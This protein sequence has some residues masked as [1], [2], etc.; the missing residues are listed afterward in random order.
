M[1]VVVVLVLASLFAIRYIERF[2]SRRLA[3]LLG[4]T[5]TVSDLSV[6]PT[7]PPRVSPIDADQ[8]ALLGSVAVQTFHGATI[9]FQGPGS[10]VSS[11]GLILTTVSA[12]PYGSGSYVYQIATARGQ[13]LRARRLTSDRESGLVLLKVESDGL[14]A[15]LFDEQFP[16]VAGQQLE[17]IAGRVQF[18]TFA[19][20]RL[21]LW[22]VGVD[23]DGRVAVSLDRSFGYV[24][25]GGRIIDR[26]GHSV[27]VL[28]YGLSAFVVSAEKV[29]AFIDAYL[30]R[31]INQ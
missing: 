23:V 30:A 4:V 18:S 16:L 19:S 10:A 3:S 13:I 22:V 12:A 5:V 11:D 8:S 26:A 14:D 20:Q 17:V 2:P 24:V 27:G 21:P 1:G 15:V 6:T 9:V 31:E 29:N 28:R 7:T 25:N